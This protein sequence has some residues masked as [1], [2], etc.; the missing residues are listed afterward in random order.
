[1]LGIGAKDGVRTP[2]CQG[3]FYRSRR[4]S[5]NFAFAPLRFPLF[6]PGSNERQGISRQR[7]ER[8]GGIGGDK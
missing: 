6:S 3:A 2:V 7:R 4:G 8:G 1:M 5:Q